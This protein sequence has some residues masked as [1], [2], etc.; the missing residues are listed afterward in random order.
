MTVDVGS[1]KGQ[2]E[3]RTYRTYGELVSVDAAKV[4]RPATQQKIPDALYLCRFSIPVRLCLGVRQR[5]PRQKVELL[6]SLAP[7]SVIRPD[8]KV[9]GR[10]VTSLNNP[11]PDSLVPCD[12]EG[13]CENRGANDGYPQVLRYF[14]VRLDSTFFFCRINFLFLFF[15][16]CAVSRIA[17]FPCT[18]AGMLAC[19]LI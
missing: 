19:M 5:R 7:L 3:V 18:H 2:R 9:T 4:R 17:C 15:F 12:V 16:T 10:C 6:L 11:V 1:S 8:E 14:Q 13:R